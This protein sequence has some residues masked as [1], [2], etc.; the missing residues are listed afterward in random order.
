MLTKCERDRPVDELAREA[1]VAVEDVTGDHALGRALPE[2]R[3][4]YSNGT[5][6]EPSA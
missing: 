5:K 1:A 2:G 3:E 4:G 6:R